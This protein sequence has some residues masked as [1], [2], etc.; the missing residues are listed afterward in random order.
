MPSSFNTIGV[1]VW[2]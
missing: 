2:R 1:M